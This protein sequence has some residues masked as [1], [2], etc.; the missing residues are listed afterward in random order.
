M[1]LGSGAGWGGERK[2]P[3]RCTRVRTGRCR[4]VGSCQT[5]RWVSRVVTAAPGQVLPGNAVHGD[6]WESPPSQGMAF[7]DHINKCVQRG[8]G[9]CR[10]RS[11]SQN[12]PGRRPP[13]QRGSL[14]PPGP[15]LPVPPAVYPEASLRSAP[16]LTVFLRAASENR[17][18]GS[19]PRANLLRAAW[20]STRHIKP[21]REPLPT[22]CS[23]RGAPTRRGALPF[24][25]GA[26]CHPAAPCSDGTR[27]PKP[28]P[29]PRLR[30]PRPPAAGGEAVL[31][32]C[33]VM[34]TSAAIP[35][36]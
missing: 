6:F 16:Q 17:G 4:G 30:A 1:E 34:V 36:P 18:P 12:T 10:R 14:C 5:G 2:N 27:P 28:P 35:A 7:S 19:G 31:R 20:S 23:R 8:T 26:G 15:P 24:P 21:A 33:A 22:P 13:E 32:C 9:D 3:H 29:P 25:A 11:C